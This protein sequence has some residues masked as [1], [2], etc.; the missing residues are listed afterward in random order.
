M[1]YYVT[2]ENSFLDIKN[3]HLRVTGNVHTDVLK[4]GSI[5]FQPAGSNISGTV[6][7]TN[8]T[9]GVTTT[10]N[11]DVGGTL[12]LGT[13]ELS[14][15][16]HT[17]DHITARGNVTSTT[18][19]F[20]NAHTSL[21]TSGNVEVGGELTVSGNVEVGGDVNILS[22]SNVASIKKDSNVVTEFP[23]SKKLI[24]YPR[25]LL[26][27]AALNSAY[28]N[29]YK[30]TFSHESGSFRAYHPFSLDENSSVGWHSND[31][32]TTDGSIYYNGGTDGKFTGTTRLAAET[33]KGEW[34]GLELPEAIKLERIRM[35]SQSYST[36]TNTIDDFIV[37][38]KKQSGDTWTNI[39][40]FIGISTLQN[41]SHGAL[42][43]I[44][45][46]EYYK[47]FA[48]VATKSWANTTGV[49]IR[50]L[51][52]YGVPE[53]DP[54]AHGTD[55]VIKSVANVP[56]TDWLKVYYDAKDLTNISSPISDLSGN[57]V[58]G[59]VNGNI[60]VSDRAF[61]F[62]GVGDTITGTV[63]GVSGD[64]PHTVTMWIK[65]DDIHADNSGD[66]FFEMGERSGNKI[67]GLYADPTKFHYYFFSNDHHY[68]YTVTNGV[69]YHVTATY[70]GGDSIN[71]RKLY[72]NGTAIRRT[73]T[74]SGG[75]YTLA[76]GNFTLGGLMTGHSFGDTYSFKGS[77]ANFRFFD[78]AL[79]SDEIGQLY[80]YQKEEFGHS[81]NNLTL[82][83][84][85]LGIG[86]S[87]PRA[88]LD[89]KGD[90]F[91]RVYKGGRTTFLTWDYVGQRSTSFSATGGT[92]GAPS[93]NT[94]ID[95]TFTI[96]SC[97][98][99]LGKANLK[100]HV[101]ID[102]R[103]ECQQSWN[104]GFRIEIRYND[105]GLNTP[106]L[107]NSSESDHSSTSGNKINGL[108]CISYYANDNFDSTP[109]A[110]SVTS[111]FAL[112]NCDVSPGSTLKVSLVGRN[113]ENSAKTVWTGRTKGFSTSNPAH[114][115]PTTSFF[116]V[117]D[118][119]DGY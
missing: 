105:D 36:Q 87:E 13:I 48:I 18:V 81:T 54:D 27:S 68:N 79:S 38:A 20:D 108:P 57:S 25:V 62:D 90:T 47:F 28:E 113:G 26:T 118:V 60:N 107:V 103:G 52:Y 64:Y 56:N 49:S 61:V 55:V 50:V 104:F 65:F 6:N 92:G 46:A 74:G 19:Q 33:E 40:T 102:W 58:N 66:T 24:K 115:L 41:S 77:I 93:D 88:M 119:D 2:N 9:T 83:G 35:V 91:S 117:L 112:P 101:Q 69:W 12:N 23:R 85:R 17:L 100:A 42:F 8:V 51:D 99:H 44:N 10:S 31:Y 21:V 86:T 70:S 114:E 43:D 111:T 71:G 97:Y 72:I 7:F 22:V 29:G 94:I 63:P 53:Y 109:E 5:G 89:V 80:T 45:T 3:A 96:P 98:H 14:A 4:V 76:N 16:T 32:N 37:Y 39:G 84:G 15:S 95:K 1:S 59:A 116:V 11:L 34:L 73:T 110:A 106:T 78:R 75:N 30:V 67:I 82:K